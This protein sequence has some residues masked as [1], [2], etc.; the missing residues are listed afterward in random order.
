MSAYPRI[1]A[2]TWARRDEPTRSCFVP[3]VSFS[4]P[5]GSCWRGALADACGE[6]L[7][8]ASPPSGNVLASLQRELDRAVDA[9]GG[10]D[11]WLGSD[12][13]PPD[14]DL[15]VGCRE[16]AQGS[17]GIGGGLAMALVG[18]GVLWLMRRA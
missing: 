4:L 1:F 7:A 18:V 17:A 9:A 8:V 15:L 16:P 14:A 5:S 11:A 3:I 6:S 10:L 2:V 12:G 13:R